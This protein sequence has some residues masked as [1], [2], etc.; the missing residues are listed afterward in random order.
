MLFLNVRSSLRSG[1]P[2]PT[3]WL[4]LLL[5]PPL[6]VMFLSPCLFLNLWSSHQHLL[7]HLFSLLSHSS[8]WLLLHFP[9]WVSQVAPHVILLWSAPFCLWS[10]AGTPCLVWEISLHHVFCWFL[11][12]QI[13]SFLFFLKVLIFPCLFD[14]CHKDLHFYSFTLIIF[15]L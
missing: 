3:K 14:V 11:L 7:A 10:Q 5:P 2:M 6:L 13:R 15:C 9:P 1:T 12:G 4:L 8:K